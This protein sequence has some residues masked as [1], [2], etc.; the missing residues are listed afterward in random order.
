MGKS[1]NDELI[2]FEQAKREYGTNGK[3][4][5]RRKTGQINTIQLIPSVPYF[6][7]CSVLF[8]LFRTL[9]SLSRLSYHPKIFQL[10]KFPDTDSAS[11]NESA[12]EARSTLEGL[13][14]PTAA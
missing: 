4:R 3:I 11:V 8:R 1:A 13:A 9:S 5:N 7:V 2:I 14:P 6:S 12:R 10:F